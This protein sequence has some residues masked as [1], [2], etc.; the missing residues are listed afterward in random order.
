VIAATEAAPLLDEMRHTG[1]TDYGIRRMMTKGEALAVALEGIDRRQANL[2]KQEMLAAGGDV[3]VCH[4]ISAEAVERTAAVIVGSRRQFN[5]LLAR[6]AQEP[7]D[8]PRMGEELR[9]TLEAY[10]RRHFTIRLGTR[11][12][13]VGPRPAIVGIVNVTPDSFSDGGQFRSPDEAVAHG[14]RLAEEG[15]DVLDIGGESTRPGSDPVSEDV[16]L[17]RVMPVIE[18]LVRRAGI[19]LSIDT[20][21]ARVAREATAAGACLVNDV[22]GLQG[23]PEM[24]RT[25]AAAGAGVVIMH[26]LG[27]PK[28]MQTDPKYDNLMADVCRFLRRGIEAARAAGVPEDAILVDP[29]LGFGKR[30]EHN[31]GVLA[32]LGQLRSLG[33]PILVGPS[34][35]RFIGELSGVEVPSERLFGTA[36]A[37][38][39]AVAQGALLVRVHDVAAMRQALAVAAAVTE[40]AG[41]VS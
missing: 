34:R 16:E 30:L 24:A 20:R 5:D 10:A 29:G 3:A 9:A 4:G 28:T 21:R 37:C 12:L 27:E 38:A 15:A 7:F 26:R 31:L 32:R 18:G 36:A 8:L 23:D 14:V 6:L 39:L 1:A 25:V 13:A 33:C 22:T 2:L 17:A 35:K 41:K 40:S 19:P 11:R